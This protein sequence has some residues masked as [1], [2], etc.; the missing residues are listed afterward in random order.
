MTTFDSFYLSVFNHYKPHFKQSANTIAVIYIS[1]LQIALILLLGAFFAIFFEQMHVNTL[2]PSK[3]WTLFIISSIAVYFR[4]WL[5]YTGKRRSVLNAKITKNK[6]VAYN[7]W[8]LWLLLLGC[9]TLAFI[10]LNA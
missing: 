7:I 6:K 5:G 10:I 8:L 2:S 9:I 4:N 3:A 1:L